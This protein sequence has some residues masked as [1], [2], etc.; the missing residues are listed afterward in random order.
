MASE[1]IPAGRGKRL[2]FYQKASTVFSGPLRDQYDLSA[3]EADEFARRVDEL[4][5]AAK[6][7]LTARTVATSKRMAHEKALAAAEEWYRPHAA[8]MRANPKISR[9]ALVRVGI[10]RPKRRSRINPPRE[11]PTVLVREVRPGRVKI[12]LYRPGGRQSPPPRIRHAEIWLRAAKNPKEPDN[13]DRGIRMTISGC[14]PM[15]PTTGIEA[16]RVEVCARWMTPRGEGSPWSL[17]VQFM[18]Q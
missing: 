5:G 14:H 10:D 7:A 17:P 8:K 2:E 16:S 4:K 1:K 6:A 3:E 9:S 18:R 11:R 12:V 13:P 15:V